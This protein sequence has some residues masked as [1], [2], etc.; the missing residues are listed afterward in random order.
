M[1]KRTP[2][3]SA[4]GPHRCQKCRTGRLQRETTI[5]GGT[6][7]V[8]WRCTVCEAVYPAQRRAG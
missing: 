5:K 3:R 7:T 6:T 4:S 2:L 1:A 8:I